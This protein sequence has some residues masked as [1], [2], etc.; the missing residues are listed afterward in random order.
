MQRLVHDSTRL[1]AEREHGVTEGTE[2]SFGNTC[3]NT[4]DAATGRSLMAIT[5][6]SSPLHLPSRNGSKAPTQVVVETLRGLCQAPLL[7]QNF[8]KGRNQGPGIQGGIGHQAAQ[9]M[10]IKRY[11]NPWKSNQIF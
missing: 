6:G 1:L 4:P 2:E 8:R 3:Q 7:R 9:I 5:M 10:D 11:E